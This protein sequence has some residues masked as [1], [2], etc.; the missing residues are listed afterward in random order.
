MQ[1][2]IQILKDEPKYR[3]AQCYKAIFCDLIDSWQDATNLPITLRNKLD[4]DFPLNIEVDF[5]ESKNKKTIKALIELDDGQKIE[6]V[7]M[8]Y[9]K[10]NT[11][12][13]SSQVGCTLGCAF[14][15]TGQMGFERNLS[16]WEIVLQVLTFSKYLKLEKHGRIDNVV[17]M[18]MG[19]PFLNYENVIDAAKI[20]NDKKGFNIGARHMSISTAGILEGIDRLADEKMQIN[21]AI[22]LHAPDDKLRKKLMPIA[23]K[24]SIEET[25]EVVD[26]YIAKT[27][28]KVMFEYLLI[29]G[30]N[31]QSEHAQALS[32]LMRRKL[33][34]LN[35]IPCNPV[36]HYRPSSE[37]VINK[38]KVIL[39]KKG[40]TLTQ[41]LRF[42]QDVSGA[43]GQLASKQ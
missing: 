6:S 35:L 5:F 12:C 8:H 15:A 31:D 22:S 1:K 27:S 9:D 14:C 4:Q 17:F 19:E 41:R 26:R 24:Y 43:C 38:F 21:L 28:R 36:R 7:L 34:L 37:K 23:N 18:G 33:Y 11:V 40:V 42:G 3:L 25:L 39:E 29:D 32:K 10:R 16:D 30:I 13:V 20:F 2:L